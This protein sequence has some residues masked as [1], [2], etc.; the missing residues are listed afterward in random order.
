[1]AVFAVTYACSR[2]PDRIHDDVRHF[3]TK[4]TPL[5]AAYFNPYVHLTISEQSDEHSTAGTSSSTTSPPTSQT[6]A[7]PAPAGS[8]PSSVTTG[9]WRRSPWTTT[10][11]SRTTPTAHASGGTRP[12]RAPNRSPGPVVSIFAADTEPRLFRAVFHKRHRRFVLDTYLPRALAK[13][14]ELI[15]N[16]ARQRRLFTN[17]RPGNRSTWCHVPF[18]HPATFAKLAMDP[19]QKKE[20][21]HRRPRGVH[22]R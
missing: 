22:G 9:S 7:L 20:I 17:H 19:V 3:I 5:L 8:R 1:M 12:T 15:A 13:G 18:E 4:W 10:C 11:R 6:S 14:Q 16:M 2:I 21:D